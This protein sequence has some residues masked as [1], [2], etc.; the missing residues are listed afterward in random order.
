MRRKL[1][2][3]LLAGALTISLLTG[4][5]D[6]SANNDGKGTENVDKQT[7][8][9][10]KQ[11][12]SKEIVEL[13]WFNGW[14]NGSV[15]E[16]GFFNERLAEEVGIKFK[17]ALG[18]G[19]YTVFDSLLAA[20]ELTDIVTCSNDAQLKTATE[21]GV[22][23]NLEDYKEQLPNIFENELY[24]STNKRASSVTDG[25]MYGA[26]TDTGTYRGLMYTP[27]IQWEV[28]YELGCP[29][30]ETWDDLLTVLKDMQE[31]KPE[32]ESGMKTYAFSLWNDW[33]GTDLGFADCIKPMLGGSAYAGYYM[34]ARGNLSDDYIDCYAEDSAYLEFLE[35]LFKANQMGLVDPESA[36]QNYETMIS[37]MA[38]GAV[39]VDI[40]GRGQN[41]GDFEEGTGYAPFNVGVFNIVGSA[42]LPSGYTQ[43][44]SISSKT[45][46]LDECLAFLNW[47]YD[48]EVQD[49][50]INGPEGGIWE[51]N[52]DKSLR[53][54][55]E[56]F[57]QDGGNVE[58][59]GGGSLND[60]QA[61]VG[62]YTVTT[63]GTNLGS[64]VGSGT[65]C[66]RLRSDLNFDPTEDSLA[67]K[68]WKE[69]YGDQYDWDDITDFYKDQGTY[70][71]NLG[72]R[73]FMPDFVEKYDP[74]TL[75]MINEVGPTIPARLWKAIYAADEN[76]F[77]S[78]VNEV[79]ADLEPLHEENIEVVEET[80]R[81]GIET[82]KSY[83]I[84]N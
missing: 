37:K 18:C 23:I 50:I 69:V 75:Q 68:Q 28:Y 60:L 2:S 1:L 26:A 22:L 61:F 6:D 35:F 15:D 78:Y 62:A 16:V 34:W 81:E 66:N 55:T 84:G 46:H 33:D 58:I 27:K 4:C 30:I 47:Y 38:Q 25:G 82:G 72:Q 79:R 48:N 11:D 5:G 57:K 21:A 45:E 74:D 80:I 41:Y 10:N 43:Y 13:T 20:G 59:E 65:Q 12:K 76:E 64:L 9:S 67:E 17:Q 44:F 36:T 77:W 83:G 3:V 7:E 54:A 19:D 29:E 31:L 8:E 49:W 39:L 42:P 40:L 63:S 56:A 24:T 53:V 32:T 70:E 73:Q 14:A 51:W 71:E 52:E